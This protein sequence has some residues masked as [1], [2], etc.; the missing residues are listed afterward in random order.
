MTFYWFCEL[1]P[2]E[3]TGMSKPYAFCV[4]LLGVFGLSLLQ[5][6]V[7]AFMFVAFKFASY[8]FGVFEKKILRSVFPAFI[9]VIFEWTQAQTWAG[10]AVGKNRPRTDKCSGAYPDKLA[11]GTVFRIVCSHLFC[12]AH[13]FH[14]MRL[15][16]FQKRIR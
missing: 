7:W 13:G 4:V 12:I 14:G 5:A 15:A 11:F 10:G 6:V 2:L 3:F 9:W 8:K 16:G 1:Y